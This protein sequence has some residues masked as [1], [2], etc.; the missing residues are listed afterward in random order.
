MISSS[1]SDSEPVISSGL[2]DS[3]SIPEDLNLY[4]GEEAD[5]AIPRIT[6]AGRFRQRRLDRGNGPTGRHSVMR[7]L[8]LHGRRAA[9]HSGSFALLVWLQP[10][11][12]ASAF[13]DHIFQ[14]PPK[15]TQVEGLF[16]D[17]DTQELSR[18][19]HPIESFAIL[20]KYW[21]AHPEQRRVVFIGNSQMQAITL[22]PGEGPYSEPGRTYFDLIADRCRQDAAIRLQRAAGGMSYEEALWYVLPIECSGPQTGRDRVSDQS[23]SSSGKAVSATGCWNC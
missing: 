22:A 9:Q 21:V 23:I 16:R 19:E 18:G 1:L 13:L 7:R 5:I 3:L 20:S 17:P 8:S 14:V 2:I 12:R 11:D 4:A 10:F 15:W 6:S